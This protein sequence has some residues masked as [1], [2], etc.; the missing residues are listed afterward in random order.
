MEMRR[1]WVLLVL[2]VLLLFVATEAQAWCPYYLDARDRLACQN[3]EQLQRSREAWEYNHR[4]RE[5]NIQRQILQEQR[6]ANDQQHR[7]NLLD[8]L[9]W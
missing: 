9:G 5:E 6:R 2:L 7:R 8:S 4:L 1:F 3:E